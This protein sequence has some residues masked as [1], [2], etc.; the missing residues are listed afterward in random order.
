[1][2]GEAGRKIV[3]DDAAIEKLLD[4]SDMAAGAD[5]DDG[6][7]TGFMSNFK[8]ANF[9]IVDNGEGEVQ[10]FAWR[11]GVCVF[12]WGGAFRFPFHCPVGLSGLVGL[13]LTCGSDGCPAGEGAVC[14]YW[15]LCLT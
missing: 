8:V 13:S 14:V 5:G 15:C 1:V 4:R 12:F 10:A 6:A 11:G 3:Y 9:E 7:D 2:P